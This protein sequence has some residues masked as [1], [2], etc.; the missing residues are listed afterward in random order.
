[1]I[2]IGLMLVGLLIVSSLTTQ[3]YALNITAFVHMNEEAIKEDNYGGDLDD[4][5][6][7][8]DGK[9]YSNTFWDTIEVVYGDYGDSDDTN[10][11]TLEKELTVADNTTEICLQEDSDKPSYK[12]CS[13]IADSRCS[14]IACEQIPSEVTEIHFTYPAS[15]QKED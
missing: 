13:W 2:K 5:A 4:I 3:V 1:M 14:M 12:S 7:Y 10:F 8:V 6:F 11:D 15:W 9:N